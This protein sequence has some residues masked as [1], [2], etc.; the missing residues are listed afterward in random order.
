[1]ETALI[2]EA[3]RWLF[4]AA[5]AVLAINDVATFRI[6]NWANAGVAGG[7][8]VFAAAATLTGAQLPWLLHLG[9]AAA[10][11]AGGLVLFQMQAM[12]GGDVKLLAAAALWVGWGVGLVTFLV[13]VGLVGGALVLLLLVLRRNLMMV[14]VWAS[15]RLPQSWPRV[16]THGEKVP[17]G[18]AI[19]VGAIGIALQGRYG[20]FG[21]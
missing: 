2:V 8:V 19:A 1:M 13:Y 7:F 4:I 5:M 14:L 18:V 12:G 10:V 3:G 20:L 17:Y 16:L 21:L 11:F 6:P 9:A 15:P